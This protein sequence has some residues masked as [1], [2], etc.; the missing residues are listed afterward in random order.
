MPALDNM[1]QTEPTTTTVDVGQLQTFDAPGNL[2]NYG[3]AGVD[4]FE[5]V[6]M[7]QTGQVTY[8]N[9]DPEQQRLLEEYE[10][11]A[12]EA[13]A[14]NPNANLPSVAQVLASTDRS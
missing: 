8:N 1:T 4:P 5:F 14:T 3:M 10:R 13:N 2:M 11:R 7:V 9:T 6:K 12:Q